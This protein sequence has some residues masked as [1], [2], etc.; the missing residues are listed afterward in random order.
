MDVVSEVYHVAELITFAKLIIKEKAEAFT[1]LQICTGTIFCT[2]FT[3]VIIARILEFN[4]LTCYVR[5][6]GHSV[7]IIFFGV[8]GNTQIGLSLS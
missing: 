4:F 6:L 1:K 8:K 2:F 7:L 3:S 5:S